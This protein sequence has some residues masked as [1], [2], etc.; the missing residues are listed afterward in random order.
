MTRT[1]AG[2]LTR[3]A[4]R[5]DHAI[6]RL[7]SPVRVLLDVR[8]PMNLGVLRPVWRRL[9]E[10]SRIAL[11]FT[12]EDMEGVGEAL[13]ADGLRE[14][15][16]TRQAATWLRVDLAM[17]AD[18]WNLVTLRR[19]RRW[20]NF[21]HGVAGKY[22]LDDPAKMRGAGL[23]RFDRI[24]FINADR[25][26]RYL[27]GGIIDRA[28]AVLVG[29]P[30][31][32]DLVNGAWRAADVRQSL[33]LS[34]TLPTVLYAPTFSTANSLHRAG[35]AIIEALL[36][37]EQNVIV[38]L[39]DRSMVPDAKHT[40]GIDWPARL[41]R[42]A[43]HPRFALARN[44]DS[45]PFLSAADLLVTDHSTVGF[46]FALLNRPI[47][48]FDAPELKAVARIDAGKWALLRSMADVVSGPEELRAAVASALANPTRGGE[49][50]RQAHALFANAGSATSR[51]VALVY[52]LLE[53]EAPAPAHTRPGASIDGVSDHASPSAAA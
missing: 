44:A 12:A 3:L 49:A 36:A 31:A 15:L 16:I 13:G 35:E 14:R 34:P 26:Q 52:E 24:A 29:F 20:I 37:S 33:G 50:R 38:K 21:F 23:E 41:E 10:D 51:A 46:E 4:R 25:M 27:D 30:K 18:P 5:V 43:G 11:S 28:Q 32:D 47:V 22:D 45:A 19:C 8:T 42:F 48:V 6:G 53:L 1:L 39:H 17:S 9:G 40:G 2:S 7:T